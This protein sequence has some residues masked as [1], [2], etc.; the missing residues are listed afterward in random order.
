MV[1]F[2]ALAV[3]ALTFSQQVALVRTLFTNDTTQI[4]P[5]PEETPAPAEAPDP[6]E[7]AAQADTFPCVP[8]AICAAA[9]GILF[10]AVLLLAPKHKSHPHHTA[11]Q[12][13]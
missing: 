9:F 11:E 8:V 1:A 7:T 3:M 2:V 10:A 12:N 5:A 4:E 6:T 13:G